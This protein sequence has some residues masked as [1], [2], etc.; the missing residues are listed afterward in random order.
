MSPSSSNDS[1]TVTSISESES[2]DAQSFISSSS[3][4]ASSDE[5]SSDSEPEEVSS[6]LTSSSQLEKVIGKVQR[7]D[8]HHKMRLQN[9]SKTIVLQL[10]LCHPAKG[11]FEQRGEMRD[12]GHRRK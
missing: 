11:R 8:H 12:A 5:D 10:E 7:Q 2:S 6:Q 1:S 9:N 3:S 4:S